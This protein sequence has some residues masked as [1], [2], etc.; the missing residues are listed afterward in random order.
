MARNYQPTLRFLA[1]QMN[2]YISRY[3]AQLEAGMTPTQISAL[4]AFIQCLIELISALG[5]EPVNP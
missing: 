5:E 4:L 2:V 3:Q 1:R